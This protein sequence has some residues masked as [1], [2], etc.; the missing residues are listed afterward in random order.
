MQIERINLEYCRKGQ[1]WSAKQFNFP[2]FDLKKINV[3]SE[4]FH[5]IGSLDSL[6]EVKLNPCKMRFNPQENFKGQSVF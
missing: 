5:F 6:L 2:D 1:F 3:K 4:E